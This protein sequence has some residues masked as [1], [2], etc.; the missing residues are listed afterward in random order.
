M[1]KHYLE[2]HTT[3]LK[4]LAVAEAYRSAAA[5]PG[6][7]VT[8]VQGMPVEVIG[9]ASPAEIVDFALSAQRDAEAEERRLAA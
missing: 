4:V 1:Q 6:A 2:N 7:S 8:M 9:D 3:G 5:T